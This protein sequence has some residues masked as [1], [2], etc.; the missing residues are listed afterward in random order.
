MRTAYDPTGARPHRPLLDRHVGLVAVLVV[1]A[2][3]AAAGG[4]APNLAAVAV[5]AAVTAALAARRHGAG[6]GLLLAVA[7]IGAGASSARSWRAARPDRLGPFAGWVTVVSDPVPI[8][9]GTGVVVEV[10]GQRFQVHGFGSIGRRLARLDAGVLVRVVGERGPLTGPHP[11][12]LVARH[13]VGELDLDLVGDARPGAPVARASNRVRA[14]LRRGAERAMSADDAALFTGLVIGDDTRQSAEL[15][16]DFRAAGLSH[17]TAVSGQNVAFTL[18]IAGVVLRRLPRW[19]RLATTLGVIAWFAVLTRLEPSVLRAAAMASLSAVSF[20]IGRERS[21]PRLL[22]LAVIVLVVV[23]P[24]LVWSVAFWLS[25]GATV[26]VTVIAP[27]LEHRLRGPEWLVPAVA[28]TVGAQL[29]VA[30]PSWLVFHRLPAVGLVANLLAVPVA[31]IVMLL[32]IPTGLVAAL[33]PEVVARVVLA[34]AALG[35]RWVAVV[36]QLAARVEPHGVAA[37]A[38]WSFQAAVLLVLWGRS[39]RTMP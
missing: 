5:L 19:W 6:V 21:P 20:A 18:A 23:D 36:A 2:A 4:R 39:T 7:I 38:A 14:L 33:V 16:A 12:R 34:P 13:V 22:A 32:G 10:E 11:R 28:V 30:V 37:V 9:G 26:G 29:G 15:V 31:G 27:V 17:L 35:T 8:R 24:F 25:T 3:W 1:L